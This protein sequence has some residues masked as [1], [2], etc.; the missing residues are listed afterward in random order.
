MNR[1][2]PAFLHPT[3]RVLS[4][5]TISMFVTVTFAFAADVATLTSTVQLTTPESKDQDD[6]CIWVHPQDRA[7]ST[8]IASDKSASKLFVYDL[9][10]K[11]LQMIS[12]PKPGNIDLR[13]QV[14]LDGR[15]RDLVVVNQRTDGFKLVIFQVAPETRQLE[16]IDDD[17]LTGPNY[18]GCLYHSAKTGRL[19]F[20]C[21]SEGGTIEQYELIGNGHH[22]VKATKVRTLTTGKCEGAVADDANAALFVSEEQKGIWKFDAEPAG[23]TGGTLIGPIGQNGLKGDVEGLAIFADNDHPQSNKNGYLVVSDQGRNRFVAYQR[24]APHQYVG[25]FAVDGASQTDGIEICSANLG[26]KFPRGLFACHTD[27]SP[28]AVLLTPWPSIAVRLDQP[29]ATR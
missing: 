2:L 25:E 27:V 1:M 4:L 15:K 26:P 24:T 11:V 14:T 28:R 23:S 21:T 8:V 10:R 7:Q 20:V 9:D 18:G 22:K 6:F 29:A 12:V 19:F 13:Q 16:R 5:C 3:T 17:C